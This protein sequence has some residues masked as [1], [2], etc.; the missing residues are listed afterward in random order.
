MSTTKTRRVFPKGDPLLTYDEAAVRA[1]CKRI[2][3]RRRVADGTLPVVRVGRNA[4]VPQSALDEYI[5]A[6][7]SG[8]EQ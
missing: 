5:L 7:T 1:G 3:I 4:R 6:C 2:T 8:G